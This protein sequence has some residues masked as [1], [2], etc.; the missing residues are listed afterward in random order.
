MLGVYDN[1]RRA[2]QLIKFDGMLYDTKCFTDFDAVMEY[3]DRAWIVFEVKKAGKDVPKGQ[4]L[5]LERFVR[6]TCSSGKPCIAAVV[7]HRVQDPYKDV[8]L[9][10]CDVYSIYTREKNGYNWRPTKRPMRA[11]E[12]ME[13][14]IGYV[15][16]KR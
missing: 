10:D 8:Y 3:N 13:A 1:E 5:A 7:W 2:R 14:F 4:R 16:G 11:Y 9:K 6:D 15:E 12:L